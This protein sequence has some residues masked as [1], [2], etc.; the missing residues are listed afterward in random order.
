MLLVDAAEFPRDKTCG[1]GLTANALRLVEEMGVTA[2]DLANVKPRPAAVSA[3]TALDMATRGGA[4]ALGLDAAV[5]SLEAG[6]RADL[7]TVSMNATRQVPMYDPVS[8]LVYVTRG[9]DVR[10]TIV[11]GK[12][13]MR[14]RKV[15]TLNEGEVV[16][17][18]KAMAL[19]VREAV[20]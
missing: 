17:A 4:A 6:K 19:K 9:D 18:A 2:T 13:L 16:A 20:R 15:A 5:G 14:D 10:N 8:H 1:D 3:Q 7:I 11:N 12:V